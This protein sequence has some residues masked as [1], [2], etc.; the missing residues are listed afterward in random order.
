[1]K[2][3]KLGRGL[4]ALLGEI[5]EAYSNEVSS[6]DSIIEINLKFQDIIHF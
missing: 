2:S 3:Q 1:M 4:G 5:D 6:G